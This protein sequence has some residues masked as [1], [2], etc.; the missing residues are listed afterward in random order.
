MEPFSFR[1][2][3]G[4]QLI[5]CRPLAESGFTNAFSTRFG[6]VSPLPDSA[7]D[8]GNARAGDQEQVGE[9]RRRFIHALG[10][11]GA[12]EIPGDSDWQLVT[13][14]QVHSAEVRSVQA[15][16]EAPDRFSGCDALTA[17][18]DRVLLG[19]QTAD[20][21]PILI[22]DR[23]TGSFA[24]VHAGWRGTLAGIVAR[25]IEQMQMCYGSRPADLLAALGPAIGPCCFEVGPEVV[26]QFRTRYGYLD[27]LVSKRQDNGHA[28]LDLNQANGR[29]LID[30]GLQ[31]ESIFNLNLCTFCR[32]DLFFSYRRENGAARPVGRLL[33][34]IGR[35]T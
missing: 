33:G 2:H 7:L 8:L 4:L 26:E 25:T 14:R 12:L 19:V 3:E 35:S 13:A 27:D 28:H 15:R 10:A 34:V 29:Q 30:C 24:A 31:A 22:A 20:C 17:D 32:N 6:G 18:L 23:R 21:L 11:L 16:A 9:N 5:I 1:D